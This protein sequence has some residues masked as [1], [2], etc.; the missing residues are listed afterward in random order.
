[1]PMLDEQNTDLEAY[2]YRLE[3]TTLA[4]K[5]P[6]QYW[7]IGLAKCLQGSA[8]DVSSENM[9]ETAVTAEEFNI[10]IIVFAWCVCILASV[11]PVGG[12]LAKS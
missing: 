12:H 6:K 3:M 2:C 10:N 5:F 7:G 9:M 8:L 4:Y 11:I 1:M